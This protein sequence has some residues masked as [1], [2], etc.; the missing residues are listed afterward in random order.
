MN[1]YKNGICI[2]IEYAPPNYDTTSTNKNLTLL[3]ISPYR[4]I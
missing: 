2:L 1:T 4:I 3:N